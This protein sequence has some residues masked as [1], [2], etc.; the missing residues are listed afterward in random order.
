MR[1]LALGLWLAASTAYAQGSIRDT[2]WSD[3]AYAFDDRRSESDVDHYE[4]TMAGG[5]ATAS[6]MNG[7]ARNLEASV[8][9]VEY[10]D[11]FGDRREEA[12]VILVL[13]EQLRDHVWEAAFVLL[14]RER[15]N[16]AFLVAAHRV[17]PPERVIVARRMVEVRARPGL[18]GTPYPCTERIDILETGLRT[19]RERCR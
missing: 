17:R 6:T 4:I 19:Q 11:F 9:Q 2:T 10:G 3:R 1:W 5:A 8:S 7:D 15:S 16:A 18:P 13:R 12:I 14:F